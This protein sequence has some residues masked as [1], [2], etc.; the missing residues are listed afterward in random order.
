MANPVPKYVAEVQHV[1]EINLV[2]QADLAYWQAFLRPAGLAPAARAGRAELL[3]SVTD[4]H[5]QGTH[6]NEC[7]LAVTVAAP[8]AAEASYL[9]QAYNSSRLF[10]WIERTFFGT[11]Y[12]PGRIRLAETPPVRLEVA[13]AQGP[14]A[15]AWMTAAPPAISTADED[16]RGPIHLPHAAGPGRYFLARLAGRTVRYPFLPDQA[17]WQLADRPLPA[18]WQALKASGA[19][20]VEWRVRADAYHART[21]TLKRA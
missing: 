16:W 6:T 10:A 15:A 18:G 17:G 1:K 14:L 8:E 7:T 3:M 11:P 13:E 9:L 12:L 21:A 20:P 2:L 5:W 4:L 19:Q